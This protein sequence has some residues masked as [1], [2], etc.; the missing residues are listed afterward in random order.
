MTVLEK[1][2]AIGLKMQKGEHESQLSA[3]QLAEAMRCEYG[4][5]VDAVAE[6]PSP[7]GIRERH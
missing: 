3:L 6:E 7:E 5:M 4:F 1:S 2:K